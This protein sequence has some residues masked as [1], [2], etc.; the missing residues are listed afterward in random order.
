[1]ADGISVLCEKLP[2]NAIGLI[3]ALA[4]FVLHNAALE[5]K[6]FLIQNRKQMAHT[7]AFREEHVVEHRSGYVFK[8]IGAVA[9]GGAV[10]VG[11]AD[12]LHG[13]D[14]GVIEILASAEHEVFEK[15]GE[16]GL[17]G[18]FV[19]RTDVVPGVYGDEWCFVIFVDQDGEPVGEDK[20]GAGNIRNGK[21]CAGCGGGSM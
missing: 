5:I 21:L 4:L 7:V 12:A 9:I 6:F 20:L 13:V 1:M 8:I 11:G 19:L 17:A 16:A 18:L 2:S 14:I 3:L 15:V 10:Q